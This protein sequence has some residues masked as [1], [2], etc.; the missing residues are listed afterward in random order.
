[1]KLSNE[2]KTLVDSLQS[3]D[4]LW[5]NLRKTEQELA[6]ARKQVVEKLG[7]IGFEGAMWRVRVY[8]NTCEKCSKEFTYV[9]AYESDICADC[10][11]ESHPGGESCLL[12]I[13]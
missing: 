12:V 7:F 1:M 13:K 4:E 10:W 5:Q 9:A 6:N 11:N 2:Q 8:S 3:I